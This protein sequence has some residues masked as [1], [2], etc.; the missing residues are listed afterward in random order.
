M[1]PNHCITVGWIKLGRLTMNET[2]IEAVYTI[3]E[4]GEVKH[5]KF[6]EEVM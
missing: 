1:S 4:N 2:R 6:Q 5:K 3:R